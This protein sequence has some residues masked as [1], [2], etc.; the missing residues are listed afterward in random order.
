MNHLSSTLVVL[1]KSSLS[2]LVTSGSAPTGIL[3]SALVQCQLHSRVGVFWIEI[4]ISLKRIVVKERV[5]EVILSPWVDASK[6]SMFSFLLLHWWF[7]HLIKGGRDDGIAVNPWTS[8]EKVVW[9]VCYNHVTCHFWPQVYDLASKLDL[10]HQ[11]YP[12][13]IKAIDGCPGRTQ[14]VS[15]DPQMLHNSAGHNAQCSP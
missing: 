4:L 13:G 15:G 7:H 5:S 6:R 2:I 11:S 8:H 12:I 10:P 3:L 1:L 9:C 14:S